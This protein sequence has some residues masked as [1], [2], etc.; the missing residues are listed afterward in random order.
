[1]NFNNI[2][3]DITSG[4]IDG[5]DNTANRRGLLKGLGAKL[6][7]A[8]VPFAAASLLTNKAYGQS[9]E[10]IINVLNYLLKLE[11]ITDKLYTEAVKVEGLTPGE[12]ST[13]FEQVAAQVKSHITILQQLVT[14][15]GG[16]PLEI[17]DE[18]IDLAGNKGFGGGPFANALSNTADFLVLMQ[19]LTDGGERMYKGQTFQVLSDK[20]TLRALMTIH[21][22]KARQA[23]F[24]RYLRNYWI[25]DDVKP[26]ITGTNSDTTNTAAQRAYAGEGNTIHLGIN[27]VGINGY[28]ISADA[29][30]QAFDEPLNM[31]DG[32]NILDR[33]LSPS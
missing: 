27:V 6:A 14:E 5:F 25:G 12:F 17:A 18:K 3:E 30:T 19:V 11:Y 16:T 20:I 28:Q 22:V 9:K 15:L 4:N 2:I 10:T 23:A 26:W 29:A 8:A 1:M 31:I 21:S 24:A 33:F 32:N 7:I 13:Q